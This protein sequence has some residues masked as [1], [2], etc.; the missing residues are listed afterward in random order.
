MIRLEV[1]PYCSECLDFEA[2]VTEP[3]LIHVI[4]EDDAKAKTDTIVRCKNA[5]R[6]KALMRYLEK[7]LKGDK[8]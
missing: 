5:R 7:Q 6:C 2:I 4:G 3:Q 1:Q 8:E